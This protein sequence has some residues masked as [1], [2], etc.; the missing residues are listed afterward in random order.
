MYRN[1]FQSS[2]VTSYR[3]NGWGSAALGGA[4]SGNPLF[5]VLPLQY[6][7]IG[8]KTRFGR[9][10]GGRRRKHGGGGSRSFSTLSPGA[11]LE[12]PAFVGTGDVGDVGAANLDIGELGDGLDELVTLLSTQGEGEE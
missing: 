5:R 3:T 8:S 7:A 9:L 11:S 10:G 1:H 6:V 2:S 4:V 12:S